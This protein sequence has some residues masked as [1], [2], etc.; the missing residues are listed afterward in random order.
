MLLLFLFLINFA[1]YLDILQTSVENYQNFS[2][3]GVVV[4]VGN[5]AL[6]KLLQRK[7]WRNFILVFSV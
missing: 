5:E 4:E 2:V 3:D 7:L 1:V 6:K